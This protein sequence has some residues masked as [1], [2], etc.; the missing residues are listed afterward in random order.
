MVSG[1]EGQRVRLG[2]ALMRPGV[3]LAI[4][5]EPFRG[6]DHRTR[7]ELLDNARQHWRGATLICIMHDVID[8]Q[9]FARVVVV[10][11]G[12]IVEDAAP[13]VLA[14]QPGSRYS[15]LLAADQAVQTA[16]WQSAIWRRLR[17]RG[18]QIHE[19]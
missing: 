13:E 1:G 3:R 8:T 7:R 11:E 5:D 16:R 9:G 4:L 12:R 14:A 10:D 6:L 2:R 17:L 18:G 15:R 19:A